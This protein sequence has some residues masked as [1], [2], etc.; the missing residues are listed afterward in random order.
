MTFL[1][2][3]VSYTAT[4]REIVRE[5]EVI[6]SALT[7]GRATTNDVVLP[8][9]AVEQHHATLEGAA[10]D[11]LRM[12][13]AG[14]RQFAHDGRKTGDDRPAACDQLGLHLIHRTSWHGADV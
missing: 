13:A 6:G 4:G 3:T 9:L 12:Y 7:I 5:R 8:D 2:R 14:S 1:I 10:G 11:Q